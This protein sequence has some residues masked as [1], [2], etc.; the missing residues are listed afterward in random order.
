M[1]ERLVEFLLD[2]LD[3]RVQNA[4]SQIKSCKIL[5]RQIRAATKGADWL[6]ASVH[7]I[8]ANEIHLSDE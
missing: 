7:P 6:E 4:E 5:A 8:P 3:E 2:R 1:D